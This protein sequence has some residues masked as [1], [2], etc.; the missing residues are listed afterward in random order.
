LFNQCDSKRE[1]LVFIA[2]LVLKILAAIGIGLL[3]S[4][5][6]PGGDTYNYLHDLELLS[7]HNIDGYFYA[8]QPRA[9]FF[10]RL[11][12]PLYNLSF[13]N[14]WVLAVQLSTISFVATWLFYQELKH[15]KLSYWSIQ[16]P[17]FFVPSV[18]F[19]SSGVLK[20]TVSF[21]V[22]NLLFLIILRINRRVEYVAVHL[23]IFL[24][25]NLFLYHLKYYLFAPVFILSGVFLFLFFQKRTSLFR[26]I[27]TATFLVIV[28]T[29]VVSF[30]HPTLNINLF[31]EALFVNYQ[32]I[33]I[34]SSPNALIPILFD[35]TVYSFLKNI[36][37]A[38]FNGFFGPT[39]LESWNVL[40][41]LLAIEN[42]IV[43]LLFVTTCWVTIK[44][45]NFRNK[46]L[47]IIAGC[48]VLFLSSVLPIASPNFGSLVRYRIAYYP[49]FILILLS[50]LRYN[51]K[52]S[53]PENSSRQT[54]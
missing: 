31:F 33:V 9:W 16:I 52:K 11:I 42:T 38:V 49:L 45:P 1:S 26:S 46:R 15:L 14:Y 30:V 50:G 24:I 43:L 28:I 3:Y 20:E 12:Y 37:Q 10:V 6:Y 29:G 54:L 23:F 25:L 21:A 48:Y 34:T 5:Y 13:S 18:C 2:A 47:L 40:S 27:I 41:L 22:I 44:A 8:N 7:R 17:L 19:W 35:G 39:L 32:K 53:L 36:P 4:D 51:Q